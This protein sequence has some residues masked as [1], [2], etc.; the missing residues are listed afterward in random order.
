MEH[1]TE[2]TAQPACYGSWETVRNS[3]AG[4]RTF[5]VVYIPMSSGRIDAKPVA[6]DSCQA[7]ITLQG[8]DGQVT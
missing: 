6:N 1:L 4:Q 2:D 5:I 8:T 3:I 7:E